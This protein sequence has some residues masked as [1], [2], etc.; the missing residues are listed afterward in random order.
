MGFSRQNYWS[1]LPFP[2]PGDLLDPGIKLGLLCLLHC[3]WI[4]YP[5]HQLG[6]LGPLAEAN[7]QR[8][9]C[10][11]VKEGHKRSEGGACHLQ[12]MGESESCLF[13]LTWANMH[14]NLNPSL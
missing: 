14:D 11:S 5:L 2:S 13:L 12:V 9:G 10:L 3:Q 8:F 1:G 6:S 4:L 7:G